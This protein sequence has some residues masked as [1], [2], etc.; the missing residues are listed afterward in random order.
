[1]RGEDEVKGKGEG[2]KVGKVKGEEGK[3]IGEGRKGD[4]KEDSGADLGL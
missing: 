4:E 2:K 3:G 1:V